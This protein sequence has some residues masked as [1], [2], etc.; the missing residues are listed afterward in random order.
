MRASVALVT[1]VVWDAEEESDWAETVRAAK[2]VERMMVE[3]LM[4]AVVIDCSERDN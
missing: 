4:I 2:M 1:R 3:N